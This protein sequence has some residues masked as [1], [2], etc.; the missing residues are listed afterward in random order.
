MNKIFRLVL[1]LVPCAAVSADA[2]TVRVSATGS[3]SRVPV[4]SALGPGRVR[5][6][7]PSFG[8]LAGTL[9]SLSATRLA[10]TPLIVSEA[11]VPVFGPASGWKSPA[12]DSLLVR[13]GPLELRLPALFDGRALASGDGSVVADKTPEPS[14][15]EKLAAFDK[16]QASWKTALQKALMNTVGGF[17]I[18][19]T[20]PHVEKPAFPYQVD[21][22]VRIHQPQA[23]AQT[24]GN[25]MRVL[26]TLSSRET[27]KMIYVAVQKELTGV[28]PS[29]P[30]D[31]D[32]A[33]EAF[34]AAL[35]AAASNTSHYESDGTLV[36]VGWG[37]GD[38]VNAHGDT[39][40]GPKTVTGNLARAAADAL[41][42]AERAQLSEAVRREA[43]AKAEAQ[44]K[45][46]AAAMPVEQTT[47]AK[48][49]A[50]EP[51]SAE[52][53]RQAWKDYFRMTGRRSRERMSQEELDAVLARWGDGK[54]KNWSA[55]QR[56]VNVLGALLKL[57]VIGGAIWA[58][59]SFW[60][61]VWPVLVVVLVGYALTHWGQ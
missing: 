17:V 41:F 29:F 49:A 1:C 53:W 50:Q 18:P 11:L 2:L 19:W 57:A 58:A 48:T 33:F 51:S 40:D 44:A 46:K 3:A 6:A 12:L 61:F 20:V 59:I 16:K 47:Q 14:A 60:S 30:Q 39:P 23:D 13:K 28:E 55:K 7:G 35:R 9:P 52:S 25:K 21:R 37:S 32:P 4:V 24:Q 5:L 45:E 38:H 42:G 27:V 26:T 54:W 56:A 31:Q 22:Q 15:A 8:G 10:A 34:Y 36:N 43:K